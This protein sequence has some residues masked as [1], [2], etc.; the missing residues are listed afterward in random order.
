MT[1]TII[2]RPKA[3]DFRIVGE[4]L[5]IEVNHTSFNVFFQPHNSGESVISL[6]VYEFIYPIRYLSQFFAV[7]GKSPTANYVN[8]ADP[9]MKP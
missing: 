8:R 7:N 9:L 4:L 2:H 3:K 1:T 6:E 5:K